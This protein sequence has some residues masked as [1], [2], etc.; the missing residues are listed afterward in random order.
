MRRHDPSETEHFLQA[1]N[2]GGT[3]NHPTSRFH[4]PFR[5]NCA[6]GGAVDQ[7]KALGRAGKDHVMVTDRVAAAQ[8]GKADVAGTAG[9]KYESRG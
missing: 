4:R 9:A 8:R 7:L 2:A 5:V 6:A 3:A 1:I